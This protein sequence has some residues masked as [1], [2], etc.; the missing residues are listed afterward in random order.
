MNSFF[1][2]F[3]L[4]G[5]SLAI[6]FMGF[7]ALCL[8]KFPFHKK[9]AMKEQLQ[10]TLLKPVKGVEP[11]TYANLKSFLTQD[12]PAYKVLFGVSSKD[13]PVIPLLH[14]LIKEFPQMQP[15]IILVEK[16]IGTNQKVNSLIAMLQYANSSI[17]IISDSDLAVEPHYLKT[18]TAPFSDP[19]IGMVTC[20]YRVKEAVTLPQKLEA[21]AINVDFVPSVLVASKIGPV[22][23]GLGA[24]MA[25]RKEALLSI[26]GF[27]VIADYLADDN[28]LGRRIFKK[29]WK[30]TLS[31]YIVD[32]ILPDITF[33]QFFSHQLRWART[34][35]VCEST[36]YFF[37]I[38][39][40]WLPFFIVLLLTNNNLILLF[41]IFIIAISKRFFLVN[42]ALKRLGST[43]KV[44][45]PLIIFKDCLN[46]VFWCLAFLGNHVEWQGRHY[47]VCSN[48]TMKEI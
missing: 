10:V 47:T 42:T 37:S 28:Q 9:N 2:W 48:G 40:Q 25:V 5:L 18:V 12:Y 30:I 43:V 27:E 24:T 17:I 14:Q 15:E 1:I 38:L 44:S 22:K 29:G 7:A 41:V 35:R 13:D 16:E 36:G 4:L 19:Q 6:V 3:S 20:M 21:L 31:E 39:T 11:E 45:L 23:F 34:Y 32:V 46:F 33:K 26:G 8:L